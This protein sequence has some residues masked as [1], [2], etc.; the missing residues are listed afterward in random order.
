LFQKYSEAMVED[1]H[2]VLFRFLCIPF[3]VHR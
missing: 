2:K 3:C 1:F